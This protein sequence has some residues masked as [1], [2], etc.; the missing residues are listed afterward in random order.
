MKI[1]VTGGMGYIGS[2]T[3]IELIN[4]HHEVVITDNLFN[5]D[6]E[7]LNRIKKITG[8]KPKFYNIDI[9]DKKKLEELF[10]IENI[11]AVIHF[12]G[13]KAV[14]ESVKDP[15]SYYDDN[16]I[17]TI[18]LLEVMEQNDVKKIVFSSSAT[19]YGKVRS[20][21]ILENYKLKGTSPYANTKIY[22]EG[23]LSD[24]AKTNSG[25]EIISLRYFNPIGAHH[26]GLLG[27]KPSGTPNNLMP[28]ILN[29]ASNKLPKLTI[30]GNNYN[31]VDGT[32][33]RDYVHIQD[34]AIAHVE[35]LKKGFKKNK[36]VV[37]NVGTGQGTSVLQLIKT[38]NEVNNLNIKYSIGPRRSG[39][40]PI[41][42][43]NVD[44]I[45]KELGWKSIYSIDEACKDA[46]NWEKSQK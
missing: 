5:S 14:G 7:V 32:G 43:A 36:Y 24:L 41:Y 23:M 1:L 19:V 8:I 38:F 18:I 45:H 4:N 22:I 34:L 17:S 20:T 16:L 35:S 33:I 21:S 39:D 42:V 37:Y 12:A 25:W 10:R 27:E 6:I 28:Y 3:A 2:H 9:R 40:V 15:L 26:S 46:W 29:V 30:F 44:K 13:L 31:T 11:Q